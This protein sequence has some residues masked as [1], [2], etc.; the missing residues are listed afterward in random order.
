M[1]HAPMLDLDATYEQLARPWSHEQLAAHCR[2]ANRRGAQAVQDIQEVPDRPISLLATG[3]PASAS[4]SVAIHVLHALP[5]SARGELAQQLVDTAGKN[6]ADVLHRCHLALELDGRAH[7]YAAHEW[8]P[9]IY[10]IGAG[11]P[12]AAVGRPARS[13]G[14]S[15][16]GERCDQ[17]GPGFGRDSRRARRRPRSPAHRLRVRRRGARSRGSRRRIAS[18]LDFAEGLDHDS[19]ETRMRR[20]AQLP[21]G[22]GRDL[23][24]CFRGYGRLRSRVAACIRHHQSWAQVRARERCRV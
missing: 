8:L 1:L 22:D 13:R 12:R 2:E 19:C 7:D 14:R 24:W 5:T 21:R 9:V 3:I 15:L 6:A 20:Q 10:D 23:R 17:P 18:I 16:V 11:G 4:F